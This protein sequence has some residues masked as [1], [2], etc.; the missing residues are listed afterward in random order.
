[1][2]NLLLSILITILTTGSINAQTAVFKGIVFDA[3]SEDSLQFA[4]VTVFRNDTILA[5]TI[6]DSHGKF[7]INNLPAGKYN[8]KAEIAGYVSQTVSHIIFKANETDY[9]FFRL[10]TTTADS[11]EKINPGWHVL[12]C[13]SLDNSWCIDTS[14]NKKDS[15]GR[16]QGPWVE[17]FIDYSNKKSKFEIGQVICEGSYKDNYKIGNWTYYT[18]NRK[19]REVERIDVY[20]NGK[21]IKSNK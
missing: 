19:F 16:K 2:R 10:L 8:S 6:T 1:M 15:L 14:K 17:R 5:K 21:L 12:I 11:L 18:P 9:V 20:E 4:S 13:D 7:V 3:I